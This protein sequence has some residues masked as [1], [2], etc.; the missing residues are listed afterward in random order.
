MN[1][2]QPIA[3]TLCLCLLT[4]VS[5]ILL[6]HG[7]ESSNALTGMVVSLIIG[8][9]ALTLASLFT[10]PLSAFNT[11][12]VLFFALIG[13]VAPPVVRYLTYIGVERL[14]AARSDPVRALTPLFA[15]VFAMLFLGE[16][17]GLNAFWGTLLIIGGVWLL[18]REGGRGG[19]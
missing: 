9:I 17:V 8:W 1:E 10:V 13:L 6:K 18:S 12:G 19:A 2:A 7:I 15:V 16:K 3:L 5:R 4:A 14:G 11:K